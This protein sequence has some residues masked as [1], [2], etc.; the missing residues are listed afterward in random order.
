MMSLKEV[1][2]AIVFGFC[3]LFS[4]NIWTQ[5]TWHVATAGS[6]I[7]G[8]GTELNPYA[9]LQKAEQQVQP[10]DTVYVHEGT[11]RNS[12]F[13]DGDIW[14]GNNLLTI[15]ANGTSTDPITFKPYPGDQVLLEFDATYGVVI[16]NSSYITF[17]G[18]EVKGIADNITQTEADDAWGL[19]IDNADGLI[20]NL[21]DEIGINYPDPSPYAR[22]DDI[23][24]VPKSLTKPSYFS[25][26][27]IV[28]S[29][30]HHIIITNNIVRDTPGSGIRSNGSDYVTISNNEVYNCTFYTTA[31]SGAVT[32]AETTVIPEGDLYAGTKII[33]E[34][35]Y[36]HHNENRMI[37]YAATKDFLHFVI[38]EGTGIFLTR[39]SDTYA[40]GYI[41]ISN[42][43]SAYNGASGIVCHK[44]FRSI[45][46]HNTTYKNGTTN[47]SA[48]GGIGINN[49][50]DVIIRNNIS[51]AEPDHWAL[52]TLA[53]P[54]TN[55]GIYNNLL[56]NE[57][58]SEVI[59][60]NLST[61][62]TDANPL[63]TDANN[64]DYTLSAASPAIDAGSTLTIQIDDFQGN[65]R[66]DGIPDIGA[67][68][69]FNQLSIDNLERINLR[70][71]PNPVN[72]N[73]Y[74]R[75]EN[76]NVNNVTIIDITGKQVLSC[77]IIEG[78][79]LDV[80]NLKPGLYLLNIKDGNNNIV[81][82]KLIV[83]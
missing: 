25:G 29:Q 59:Y 66:D 19:Y 48:A 10:G 73:L 32:V 57:N 64:E 39:N 8:N 80:S 15:T 28:A 38:D 7:T 1:V 74:I 43:I 21:E 41:Q 12:D 37:S 44:T 33:I 40:H 16:K 35:N 5:T 50:D 31:G 11:Y 67:Y 3:L 76:Q 72:E 34:K 13:D 77:S 30:S 6:D 18:F 71:Y 20:Y 58:G 17:T 75:S 49:V 26:K 14:E 22:G 54:N 78:N 2:K 70:I 47:D 51:Y 36:V 62:W 82:K 52:G 56:Y 42:N 69:Y 46:E 63:F 81:V 83:K 53:L 9:S 65:L 24:K 61:G 4:S 23:P 68:E 55:V 27:G 60:N 45:I 79:K